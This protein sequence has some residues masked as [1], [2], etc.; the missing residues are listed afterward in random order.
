M[1]SS[2]LTR[3]KKQSIFYIERLQEHLGMCFTQSK[4]IQLAESTREFETTLELWT[5]LLEEEL[6]TTATEWVALELTAPL[7]RFRI[8]GIVAVVKPCPEFGVG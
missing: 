8:I 1:S 3:K 6:L 4:T 7:L 5:T 2:E